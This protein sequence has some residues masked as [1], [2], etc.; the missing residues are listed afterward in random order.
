[1]FSVGTNA[2][3]NFFTGR[4]GQPEEVAG[5][6]EFLAL[7]PAA[8]YITG[9][10][11][12]TWILYVPL[13]YLKPRFFTELLHLLAGAYHRWWDGNVKHLLRLAGYFLFWVLDLGCLFRTL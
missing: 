13:G 1:M 5:L 10:V 7:N 4:Y 9:Q 8:S 12:V 6:V 3:F 11:G 2:S